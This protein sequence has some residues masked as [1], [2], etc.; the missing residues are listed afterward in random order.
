MLLENENANDGA[1]GSFGG[2]VA[3]AFAREGAKVF[4]AG[5]ILAKLNEVAKGGSVAIASMGP[6]RP[7]TAAP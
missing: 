6:T 3:R 5:C 4:L 2:A 1:G 7:R